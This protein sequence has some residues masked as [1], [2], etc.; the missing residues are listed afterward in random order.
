MDYKAN[1]KKRY[2]VIET[3]HFFEHLLCFNSM[4]YFND[5]VRDY[6]LIQCITIKNLFTV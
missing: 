6:F 2:M 3:K 1:Y 4:S 5:I